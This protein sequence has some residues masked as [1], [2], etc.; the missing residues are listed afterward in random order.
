MNSVV[1]K[2]MFI[3]KFNNLNDNLKN[4]KKL[5]NEV[6]INYN[7]NEIDNKLGKFFTISAESKCRFDES[8]DKVKC[9]W[10]KYS[11]DKG[12]KLN[13]H[14]LHH[15]NKRQFVCKEC[16]QQFNKNSILYNHKQ[17]VHSNVRSFICHRKDCNKTFKTKKLLNC[18]LLTHSSV[19]RFCCDK[20][21]KRFKTQKVLQNHYLFHTHIRPFNCPQKD[22]N[23]TFKQKR[24]LLT[25][26]IIH[27]EKPFK[28]ED[29]KKLFKDE[30]SLNS[31][32]CLHS[33][34]RPFK[35][36]FEDCDKGFK[37]KY[38]L[39]NHKKQVHYGI[40]THKCF[41]NNCDKRFISISA[42]NQHIRYKNSTERPYKCNF[43]QCELSYKS[44]A[45][46]KRHKYYV[47]FKNI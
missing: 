32:K 36:D 43:Q 44:L 9:F 15:L 11:C 16:N 38:Y 41:H 22:C 31:D 42:L 25:H 27:S 21:E 20:C 1:E 26:Q 30:N 8:A 2:L 34:Q 14:I 40:K 17:T 6:N 24:D 12:S 45:H 29:C 28:C 19:K 23:K 13:E 18:Y 7:F 37:M 35:C 47:H 46:L 33:K 10:P 5:V 39:E 4:L 3:K